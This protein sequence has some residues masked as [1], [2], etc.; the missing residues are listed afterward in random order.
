LIITEA[1]IDELFDSLAEAVSE[2]EG[3]LRR[4]A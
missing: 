3:L 1:Q 2:T 4:A